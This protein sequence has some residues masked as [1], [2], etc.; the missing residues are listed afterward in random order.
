[1]HAYNIL[2]LPENLLQ[3]LSLDIVSSSRLTVF[4]KLCSL[5]GL[6]LVAGSR[7]LS[8]AT[9]TKIPGYFT[10]EMTLKV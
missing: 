5:T 4:F 1:M 6:S 10:H 3:Y 7:R 9:L 2:H 8:L